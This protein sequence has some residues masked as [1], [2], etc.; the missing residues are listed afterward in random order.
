MSDCIFELFQ[1][2]VRGIEATLLAI[3]LINL[4]SISFSE[5]FNQTEM[6]EI[7]ICDQ[8]FNTFLKLSF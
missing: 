3:A 8:F 7:E 5:I 4:Q 1:L 6:S 2:I